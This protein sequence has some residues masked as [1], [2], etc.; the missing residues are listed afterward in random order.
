MQATATATAPLGGIVSRVWFRLAILYFIVA[1]GL[2]LYMGMS[3][4]HTLFP[5]HAHLNLLGWVS[6]SLRGFLYERFPAATAT[7]WYPI[8]YWVYNI[9]FPVTM[10]TL[11]FFFKGAAGLEPIVGIASIILFASIVVFVIN[12]WRSSGS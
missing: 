6:L 8:Q 7:V 12:L 3:G 4:D 9:S 11:A 2:G 1:T 10:L 5:V